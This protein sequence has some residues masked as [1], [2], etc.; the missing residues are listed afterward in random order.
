MDEM[1]KANNNG[2]SDADVLRAGDI[3]PPYNKKGSQEDDSRQAKGQPR[4]TSGSQQ[5]HEIPRFDLAEE[6]LA[7]QRKITAVKRK[8]PGKKSESL[9]KHV[10]QR[11]VQAIGYTIEEPMPALSEQQQIIAEIVARDVGRLCSGGTSAT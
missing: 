3:L 1:S 9:R 5:K 2:K 4:C 8:A 10:Q 6:I 11:Q 7:E